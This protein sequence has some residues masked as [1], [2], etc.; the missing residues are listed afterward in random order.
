M[1]NHFYHHDLFLVRALDTISNVS[2]TPSAFISFSP[3]FSIILIRFSNAFSRGELVNL[4]CFLILLWSEDISPTVR[5][6]DVKFYLTLM[7][8]F[9]LAVLILYCSFLYLILSS[10]LV[11]IVFLK[12]FFWNIKDILMQ[13]YYQSLI[14]N[15]VLL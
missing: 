1:H 8:I 4:A 3:W 10:L 7:W 6:S 13:K 12:F 9:L 5:Y 2:C 11:F 15:M 14:K